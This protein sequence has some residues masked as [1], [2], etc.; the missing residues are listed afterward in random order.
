MDPL[1]YSPLKANT[2][3]NAL[4]FFALVVLSV[5]VARQLPVVSKAVKG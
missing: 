3:G 2:I 4:G 1:Q 5:W